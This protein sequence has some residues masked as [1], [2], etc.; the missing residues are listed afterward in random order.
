MKGDKLTPSFPAHLPEACTDI[1]STFKERM[2]MII[3]SVELVALPNAPTYQEKIYRAHMDTC[4][5]KPRWI[6]TPRS[7]SNPIGQG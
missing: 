1:V 3:E 5:L 4:S 6:H 7:G 2:V